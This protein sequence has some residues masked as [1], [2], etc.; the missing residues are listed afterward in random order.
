MSNH[1]DLPQ[2]Q[3]SRQRVQAT[4][5]A[6]K[7]VLAAKGFG[8]MTLDAVCKEAGVK[9]TS[10]YRYWPNQVA[11]MASL[12]EIF[13]SELS[14]GIVAISSKT[15]SMPWR[16][17]QR[18]MLELLVAYCEDNEWI[19]AGRAALAADPLLIEMHTETIKVLNTH[20]VSF[21]KFNG[22]P[23]TRERLERAANMYILLIDSYIGALARAKASQQS[24]KAIVEDFYEATSAI[25]APYYEAPLT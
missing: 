12:V 22:M 8:S 20:M 7:K 16:D 11:L 5:D 1:R 2:Q 21:Y 10:I 3:R 18:I 15:A 17:A 25:L 23:G 24:V 4:L 9:P 14:E 19:Y 6:A 13:E